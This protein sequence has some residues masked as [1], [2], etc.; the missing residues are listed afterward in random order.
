MSIQT[1]KGYSQCDSMSASG[2]VVM[3]DAHVK[4]AHDREISDL[5]FKSFEDTASSKVIE[6]Q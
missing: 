1:I 3:F 2:I 6:I 5:D 4:S